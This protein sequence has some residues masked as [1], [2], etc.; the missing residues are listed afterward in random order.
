MKTDIGR[1]G[2]YSATAMGDMA[3]IVVADGAT[4]AEAMNGCYQMLQEQRAECYHHQAS[5]THLSLVSSGEYNEK[6]E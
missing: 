1:D 3:R 6:A 2:R 5:M 4:R